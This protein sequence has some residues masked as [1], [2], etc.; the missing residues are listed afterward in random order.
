MTLTP[1]MATALA[2][3]N[4]TLF[5]CLKV[6][7]PAY[8]IRLLDGAG[9]LLIGGELYLGRDPTFGTASLG[10]SF[11]DGDPAQA[12]HL[13]LTFYPPDDTAAVSLSS[14]SFQG[15]PVTLMVGALNRSTGQVVPDPLVLFSGELDTCTLNVS[16]G[17]RLVAVEVVSVL[18]RCFEQDEGAR[19]N[20][21]FH[22]S[23]WPGEQGFEFV[24]VDPTSLP[25]GA[26]GGRPVINVTGG[27]SA[28]DRATALLRQAGYV[29]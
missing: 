13:N 23:I 7:L 17:Q 26:E 12:P 25:W 11:S 4:V 5:G 21:G 3:A 15:S 6:Q 1:D 16:R 14:P 24:T 18:E 20:D 8:T 28:T 27:T 29:R 2:A 10:E 9:E 22:K 19:L